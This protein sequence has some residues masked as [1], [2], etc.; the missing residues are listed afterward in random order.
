MNTKGILKVLIVSEYKTY[1]DSYK[2]NE[3]RDNINIVSAFV[4]NLDVMHNGAY[5]ASKYGY[6]RPQIDMNVTDDSKSYVSF[7]EIRHPLIEHLNGDELYVTN[8]IGLGTNE[9]EN[10][11][12]D[13]VLLYGT[14][15]VGKTSIIRAI[16]IS[17][18]MA[19]SGLFVPCS[20]MVYLPYTKL[21]TR[22][23][24]NDNLFKGMSTFAVEI[25]ELR[26][27]LN[28]TNKRSMVLGDELCSGTEID[29]ARSIFITGIQRLHNS[30][31]S[32]IFATH[33]HEI[34][35]KEEITELNRL[36]MKHLTVRYD[37]SLDMLIYDR[38]LKD[39]SG[40]S[41]YGLEVCKSLHLPDDFL[42]S[43]YKLREKYNNNVTDHN[44]INVILDAKTSK[45]NSKKIVSICEVCK[46]NKAT[47]VHHLLEQATANI[48]G[49]V[50]DGKY[51]KNHPANLVPICQICHKE[52]HSPN[53]DQK[54]VKKQKIIAT[55]KKTKKNVILTCAA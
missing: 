10:I 41:M 43:A 38:K 19:Q 39:G 47:E 35:D 54:E 21:F 9:S 42:E 2:S 36:S 27:I 46:E 49:M 25:S 44:K 45:Y 20:K 40:D 18:I 29:S 15:A 3:M 7:E 8:D 1:S 26:V 51:H 14:N 24:G 6:H 30:H 16:G 28:Q 12:S 13:I 34:V 5:I 52:I 22:I 33:L 4:A 53:N 23:L 31:V 17:I 50:A 55:T 11:D 37:K 48:D 32:A